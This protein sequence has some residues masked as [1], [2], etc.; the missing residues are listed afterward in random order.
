[1]PESLSL[2]LA[3]VFPCEFCKIFKNTFFTGHLQATAFDAA[4]N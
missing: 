1:M 2:S 4:E 3:Q